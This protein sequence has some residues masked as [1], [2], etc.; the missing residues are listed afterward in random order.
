[1]SQSPFSIVRRRHASGASGEIRHVVCHRLTKWA[2][3]NAP[4]G[5][6]VEVEGHGVT[7]GGR[8]Y[9]ILYHFLF[10]FKDGKILEGKEYLDTLYAKVTLIDP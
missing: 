10:K 4:P 5:V 9:D 8:N 3:V 6:D 7:A 1:M 2:R